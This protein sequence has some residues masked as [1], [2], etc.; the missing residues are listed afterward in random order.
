MT[1]ATHRLPSLPFLAL[2]FALCAL[3]APC[4]ALDL[5]K[6]VSKESAKELGITVS[7]RTRAEDVWV[8]VEFKPTGPMKELKRADLVLTQGGKPLVTASLMA[9]KPTPESFYFDFYV[10]PAALPNATVTIVVWG[11]P[12]TGYGY[13]LKMKDHLPQAASRR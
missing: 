2:L 3:P 10:D 8:K 9:R 13:R 4:S 1:H 11:D 6:D 7:S 5:I 12:I